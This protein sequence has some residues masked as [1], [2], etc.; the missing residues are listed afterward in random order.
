MTVK[1]IQMLTTSLDARPG[2]LARV[3]AAFREAKVNVIASWGYQ[4]GPNEAQAHFHTS[5]ID[6]AAAALTKL[7][8]SPK[9]EHVCWVEGDDTLGAY[10]DVLA[11][12]AAAGINV[13]ATT[14]FA[15]G[16]KF[17]TIIFA[18]QADDVDRICAAARG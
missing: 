1:K 5:D 8:T 7:G 13:E 10:H 17:A 16:G 3:Y 9:R 15:L 14:A 4:M 2:A 18:T 12:I 11:R 6:A